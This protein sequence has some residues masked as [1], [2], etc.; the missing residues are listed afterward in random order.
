MSMSASE[1]DEVIWIRQ[2]RDEID[3]LASS[4]GR[5]AAHLDRDGRT[6]A[7]RAVAEL[8]S[9]RTVFAERLDA[10]STHPTIPPQIAEITLARLSDEWAKA[11]DEIRSFLFARCGTCPSSAERDDERA[12][13]RD[14]IQASLER[15]RQESRAAID[16]AKRDLDITVS[17]IASE[18]VRLGTF[19]TTSDKALKTIK[20]SFERTRTLH[21]QTWE[22]VAELLSEL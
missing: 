12:Q 7:H 22:R 15:L 14:A 9:I 21:D 18:Q 10:L 6:D 19:S 8:L 13:Q 11:D 17:R 2:K 3:L 4:L 5:W 20:A 1:S 16:Q